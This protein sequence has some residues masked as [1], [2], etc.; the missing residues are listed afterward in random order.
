[1]RRRE[2]LFAAAA[3]IATRK[4]RPAPTP[5]VIAGPV[6]P[7]G[8]ILEHSTE[9][10]LINAGKGYVPCDG[11][12]L[13]R[14]DYPALFNVIGDVYGKNRVPDLRGRTFQ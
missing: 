6:T 8:T 2:F 12:V 3:L 10:L 1:M 7:V 14:S 9:G 13:K 11:R 5:P 4:W